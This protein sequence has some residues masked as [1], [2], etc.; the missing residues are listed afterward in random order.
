[1]RIVLLL[2]LLMIAAGFNVTQD[3]IKY[4]AVLHTGY[5]MSTNQDQAASVPGVFTGVK[6]GFLGP[7]KIVQLV[8]PMWRDSPLLR[9]D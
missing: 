5:A 8:G 6:Q 2:R 4:C 9:Y 1:M 7:D 3:Q